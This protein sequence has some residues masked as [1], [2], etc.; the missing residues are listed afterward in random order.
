[1][2]VQSGDAFILNTCVLFG[3]LEMASEKSSCTFQGRLRQF[4]S[5]PA[6]VGEVRGVATLCY[7]RT[8]PNK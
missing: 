5:A 7:Y 8:H 6:K 3:R 2:I 1:M 4:S